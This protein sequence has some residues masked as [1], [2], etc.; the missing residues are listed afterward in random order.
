MKLIKKYKNKYNNITYCLYELNCGI[1]LVHLQNPATIDFDFAVIHKAGTIYEN[2]EKVPHG[3][4]H[5][6]EHILFRPNSTFK[7]EEEIHKYEDGSQKRPAIYI[8][9]R[10]GKKFLYL[11]GHSNEAGTLRVL[12]RVR[13]LIEFPFEKFKENFETEK[14]IVLA[15]RS[16]EE[17]SE[18]DKNIQFA[19]YLFD[20][21][22]PEVCY[23]VLGELED[24]NSI[25]L[26][27]LQKYFDTRFVRENVLFTV[28]SKKTLTGK[29]VESLEAIG[30]L[31]PIKES[32]PFKTYELRNALQYGL[33]YD[34]RMNGN[35]LYLIYIRKDHNGFD[36]EEE[37]ISSLL[38]SLIRKVGEEILRDKMGLVYTTNV[39]TYTE[40]T[41]NYLIREIGF[42]TESTKVET[43]LEALDTFLFHDLE[44]FLNSSRGSDWFQHVLSTFLYPHTIQ[45]NYELA[46]NI[47]NIYFDK[48]DIYDVNRYRKAVVK[49][50]KK[51]LIKEIR[52]LQQTPPH[53]WVESNKEVEKIVKNSSFW[54]RYSK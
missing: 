34:E 8:N 33:F 15:E 46:E 38:T 28:Q 29:E 11:T 17:K 21:I 36:Y 18:K 7:T 53:I 3:T 2:Q 47:G 41:F 26:D 5:F 12:E 25:T 10:T 54:K 50:S 24:I 35:A 39:S 30:N 4:A 49:I 32:S 43:L 44:N 22:L 27:I 37:S 6:L 19:R 51:D 16:R 14:G 20:E 42:K 31:Y 9:G 48:E 23:P 40:Y 45:F 52:L 1:K 13:S